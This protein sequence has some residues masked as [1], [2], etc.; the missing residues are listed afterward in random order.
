MSS[1][2]VIEYASRDDLVFLSQSDP[3]VRAMEDKVSRR[4]VL[5]ARQDGSPVG[6]LR[7]SYFWDTIPFMNMLFVLAP[8]R[9]RGIGT[10]L[11]SFWEA[12]MLGLGYHQVLTSTQADETAQ[13]F[14][15]QLGYTDV[16]RFLLPSE[17]SEELLLHKALS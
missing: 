3:H 5:V 11:V 16:G 6:W 12:E 2:L 15:R 4:E 9:G 1:R 8:S 14:Y 10:Q 17:P 13:H 7:F